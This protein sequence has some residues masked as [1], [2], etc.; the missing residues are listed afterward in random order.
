VGA[1]GL[2]VWQEGTVMDPSGHLGRPPSQLGRGTG[3]TCIC[4]CSR[5]H[6]QCHMHMVMV[7]T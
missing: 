4:T 7:S 2:L 1:A 3:G 5:C 6:D